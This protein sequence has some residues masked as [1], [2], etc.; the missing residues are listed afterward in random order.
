MRHIA[1]IFQFLIGF[2]LGILILAGGTTAAAYVF[3]TKMSANPPKP[4]FAEEKHENTAATQPQ[5]PTVAESSSPD[6][7]DDRQVQEGQQ[8][9]LPP[10]AYKARVTWS[11]GLSLRSEPGRE[12]ERVGGVGYNAE[13]IVLQ[14]SIDKQWQ[15]VRLSDGTQE[16]WVKAGNVEKIAD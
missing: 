1:N 3:F 13:L 12:A 11:E 5:Q 16:G 4:I 10:G 15:K 7:S 9:E 8:D 2:F 6:S 14:D